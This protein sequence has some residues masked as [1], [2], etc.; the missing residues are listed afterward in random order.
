MRILLTGANGFLGKIIV[1]V[2]EKQH[3]FFTLSTNSG[4]YSVFLNNEIPCFFETY[5]LVIHAAGK[6][7][8]I[9]KTE[10]EKQLFFDVNVG[11]TKNLLK[12][13]EKSGLPKQFVFISS[14]SVYGQESGS[15]ISEKEELQA[16]DPYGVSKIKAEREVID[17]CLRHNVTC[18]ILRLPLL[19]GENAIGNLGA[20][21]KGIEKG[22]Y[23]NI[24]G[25]TAKKSMVLA[26]DVA[27]F[28]PKVAEI[29][30]IYNLTDGDHPSFYELSNVISK[31]KGKSE[32]YN[33][34][35]SFAKVVG[36][37]GNLFGNKAPLN[38]L[39]LKKIT[40]D[41]TFDD[42][43]AREDLGWKPKTVLAYFKENS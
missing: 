11:G 37:I 6:A 16:K 23:F 12:G 30:G 27:A 32:P 26:K 7:H 41:L 29:G 14:V 22:Y 38:T 24:G 8:S 20:M 33:L 28:I 25:G 18:A 34:P 15:F 35:I 39:K 10:A 36:L 4:D 17:W 5:D 2:L 42:S 40:S 21:I 19:V 1:N 3:S 43:K 9:P 31:Q 13:L